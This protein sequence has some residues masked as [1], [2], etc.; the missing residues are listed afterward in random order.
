M[1][2]ASLLVDCCSSPS[3]FDSHSLLNSSEAGGTFAK[4]NSGS[5]KGESVVCQRTVIWSYSPGSK[6]PVGVRFER[7]LCLWVMGSEGFLGVSQVY[8]G[9]GQLLELGKPRLFP[10]WRDEGYAGSFS[11]D[12][13]QNLVEEDER[14]VGKQVPMCPVPT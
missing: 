3:I 11:L 5:L 13:G 4:A 10:N 2:I 9:G 8:V 14:R 6:G 12:L 7:F 1:A